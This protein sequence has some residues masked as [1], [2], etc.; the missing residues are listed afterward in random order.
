M[1]LFN[2]FT[3][4]CHPSMATNSLPVL[5]KTPPRTA[6][7][8]DKRLQAYTLHEL[9]HFSYRQIAK[10]IHL[11]LPQVQYA[12]VHRITPQHHHSGRHLLLNDEEINT[13]CD[14]VCASRKNRR[15]TWFEI[16][17]LWGCSE[18]AI[19]NAF[20]S[21]GFHRRIAWKKPVISEKNRVLRLQWAIEHL[22]WTPE[23]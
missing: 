12:Y 22:D 1:L 20:K 5:P 11:T 21:R 3:P 16:S 6:S 14:F 17:L 8:R 4:P 10:R 18:K 15:I 23:Q 2:F 13:L 7:T 19:D 9:G